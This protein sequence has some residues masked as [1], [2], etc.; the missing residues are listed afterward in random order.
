MAPDVF[1]NNRLSSMLDTGKCVDTILD[2]DALKYDRRLRA[3]IDVALTHALRRRNQTTLT[4][5][6]ADYEG[7]K[8]GD[9]NGISA[10]VQQRYALLSLRSL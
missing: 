3:C 10:L 4:R 5:K 6:L 2:V 9:T 1:A 8:Y 7:D